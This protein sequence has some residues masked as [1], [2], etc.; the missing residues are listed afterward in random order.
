MAPL[1]PP[2]LPP[3][4]TFFS[5]QSIAHTLLWVEDLESGDTFLIEVGVVTTMEKDRKRQAS[6]A[7]DLLT[8]NQSPIT[9]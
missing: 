7:Y 4:C 5:P 2:E 9:T 8:A 3:A 6:T 1:I